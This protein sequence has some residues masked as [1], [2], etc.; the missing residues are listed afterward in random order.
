[1]NTKFGKKRKIT[2][3]TPTDLCDI[4]IQMS[5][6]MGLVEQ[7]TATKHKE[8]NVAVK[9]FLF[10][11]KLS[12]RT[13]KT[14][15]YYSDNLNQFLKTPLPQYVNE[16]NVQHIKE[17]MSTKADAIYAMHG[18]YRALRSFFNWCIQQGYY[19]NANPVTMIKPPKLPNR[20]I[21][22]ISPNEFKELLKLCGNTFLGKRDKAI[23]MMLYDTGIRLQEIADLKLRDID[24]EHGLIKVIGKGNKER[25][26]KLGTLAIKSLWD[27]LKIRNSTLMELWLSEERRPL[28]ANGISQ[29]IKRLGIAVGI[30]NVSP[31]KFRH[32]FAVNYLRNGGDTFTLKI[33][34]G[35]TSLSVVQLYTKSLDTT[36]AVL[37]HIKYSPVDNLER[38]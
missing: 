18:L 14:L 22:I 5:E 29:A 34:L 2:D 13:S 31:H 23:I 3:F 1:M 21:P 20:I 7:L 4:I 33:L 38:I 19:T 26:V 25:I 36:D 24:L 10:E 15:R 28:S 37:A 6:K 17:C 11:Q 32:S 16:V 27:Y 12:N 8:I 30:P 9:E 35:H